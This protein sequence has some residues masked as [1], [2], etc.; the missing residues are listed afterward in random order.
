MF[1]IFT[2]VGSQSIGLGNKWNNVDF[3]MKA[4][5]ELNVDG[6]EPVS[7]RLNEV[8]ADMS[9]CVHDSTGTVNARL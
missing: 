1:E 8:E 2:L 6:F 7:G 3:V 9:S 5:H 4:S